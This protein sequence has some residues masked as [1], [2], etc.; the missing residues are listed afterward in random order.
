MIRTCRYSRTVLA[1][2]FLSAPAV[3]AQGSAPATTFNAWV[4]DRIAAAIAKAQVG[5]NGKS[6]S[7]QTTSP[8]ATSRSTSLVDQSS[9]TDFVSTALSLVPVNSANGAN[10]S[11]TSSGS[12]GSGS[13]SSGSGTSG[14]SGSTGSGTS[15][16]G[17]V[18]ATLYSLLAGFNKTSPT[19]PQFYKAHTAARQVS[20][21]AGTEQSDPTNDNTSKAGTVAG[22]K[23]T[24]YNGRDLYSKSSQSAIGDVQNAL[25]KD[26]DA[27]LALDDKIQILIFLACKPDGSCNAGRVTSLAITDR[28]ALQTFWIPFLSKMDKLKLTQDNLNQIDELISAAL[29]TLTALQTIINNSYDR[30]HQA[31]Q[32]ALAY[33]AVIRSGAGYNDHKAEIIYDYGLSKAITWTLN[34]NGN[35]IDRKTGKNSQGGSV[36][37]SFLGRLTAESSDPNGRKPVT[38]SFDFQ[39]KWLTAARP[40]YTVQSQLTI[41]I[42][43]GIDF[44]IS[45]RWTNTQLMT[46]QSSGTLHM[47]LSVDI[48]R[49]TQMFKQP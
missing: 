44:P 32:L 48:A 3:L 29:P 38:L 9:A 10:N 19:D 1:L 42:A 45:Y 30:I 26:V 6:T 5:I 18:T 35:F 36:A 4:N 46:N 27:R 12:G 14:G 25:T 33:T 37:T 16:G 20:F 41:P 31:G 21:T 11:S 15:G 49:V 7:K 43:A 17:T 2:S 13:G 8:S 47:G 28:M 40:Q 39:G 34:A 22:I 23:V 24:P